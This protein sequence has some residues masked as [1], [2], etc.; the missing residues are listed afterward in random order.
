MGTGA[1]R[2]GISRGPVVSPLPF[3]LLDV[4]QVAAVLRCHPNW[5]RGACKDGTLPARKVANAWRVERQALERWVLAGPTVAKDQWPEI[6]TTSDE[7]SP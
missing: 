5:V 1:R 7:A 2:V 3:E 4:G 6:G